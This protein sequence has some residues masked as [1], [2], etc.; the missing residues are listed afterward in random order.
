MSW[1]TRWCSDLPV[2]SVSVSYGLH[3][4]DSESSWDIEGPAQEE[5]CDVVFIE[6][7]VQEVHDAK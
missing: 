7:V 6:D 4:F 5:V 1:T 3:D 2:F